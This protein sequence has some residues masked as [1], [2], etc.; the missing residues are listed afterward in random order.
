MALFG[1]GLQAGRLRYCRHLAF[2]IFSGD[3][4]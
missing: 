4:P 1:L 3:Y 2:F